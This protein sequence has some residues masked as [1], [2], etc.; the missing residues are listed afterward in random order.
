MKT[1]KIITLGCKVN[2]YESAYLSESLVS[3]GWRRAG[4]G[5]PFDVAVVN[6]CIVTHRA[7]HQSR[8]EIR[9][10]AR[11]AR[12]GMVAVT[13]CYAQVFPDE[14]ARIEGV[15]L[16]VGNA[17]K[18][19]AAGLILKMGA[20][21]AQR[22]EVKDFDRGMA[23]ER[24]PVVDF[25]ERTRAYLKI[26]DGCQAF[27]SY[28]V[29]PYARGHYRSLP[30]KEVLVQLASLCE[31]GFK[32]IVLTGIH[33][34]KYGADLGAGAS[35]AR[36]LR[37]VG[38]E[39]LPVRIR[40]S[41]IEPNEVD[42]ALV[43]M[44][45]SEDWLCRHLHIPLQSGDDGVLKRM[46]RRYTARE[47]AALIRKVHEKDPFAAVGADVMTGFPG[48]DAP[49]HRNTC[50]LIE[51]LPISYLHV[52]P[53]SPRRGTPAARFEGKIDPDTLK[54]RAA[55]LR[56]IG[57]RKR[58]RFYR[59]CV[60]GTFQVLLEGP[61]AGEEEMAK[62][63]TDNYLPVALPLPLTPENEFVYAR[64]ERAESNRVIASRTGPRGGGGK[65]PC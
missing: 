16:I 35:L 32:E 53:Y 50:S 38:K 5:G 27:C 29:V 59:S 63:F 58:E 15:R 2:Q 9:R 25:S 13:G 23:I 39:A 31:R 49:A 20:S 52:F 41:S 47:F 4:E 14:L 64:V 30:E 54:S 46:N 10:A 45:A 65:A 40:L 42:E 8:Q 51:D 22:V 57:Q 61:C 36:L 6:T 33:L 37:A 7:A 55:E 62:G 18:A 28:C 44:T 26:Q 24:L 56:A 1:F 11:E 48:E 43:E 34:G 19:K 17:A 60:G 12:N 21:D 3:A